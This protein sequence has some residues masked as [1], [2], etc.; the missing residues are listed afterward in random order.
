MTET[1]K[2]LDKNNDGKLS[3]EELISGYQELSKM[4][5]KKA[6]IES[7]KVFQEVDIDKSGFIDYNEYITAT[8]I[9]KN[10]LNKEKLK[11][12]FD[13]FD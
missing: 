7:A 4:N 12:A 10:N 6:I 11:S 8:L 9:I 13:I 2:R 3:K 1:F 5:K